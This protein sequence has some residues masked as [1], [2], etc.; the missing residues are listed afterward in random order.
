MQAQ[1]IRLLVVILLGLSLPAQA[2]I[3]LPLGDGSTINLYD[4]SYALLIGVSDYENWPDLP[5]VEED[6]AAVGRGL[7]KHGFKVISLLNPTRS[8]FDNTMR[9]FIGDYGQ[10]PENRLIIYYAGH[11]YTLTTNR[12]RELGYI[13]PADAPLPK[14]GT[15]AFKKKAISMLEIEIFAKQMESKHAMFTFDSC[16]SG[17]LFEITRA[18]PDTISLKTSEPVRQFITAGSAE[19]TVPD[20]S[21]FRN[22]FVA[23]LEGEADINKDGFITGTELAQYIEESVTNYTRRAQTPQYG[24][25]RDPYLDKG[26]FVFINPKME[27][28]INVPGK[29]TANTAPTSGQLDPAAIELSYWETIKGTN[30]PETYKAYLD[31]YPEGKFSKLAALLIKQASK[32]EERNRVLKLEREEEQRRQVELSR[33]RSEELKQQQALFEQQQ[34]ENEQRMSEFKQE[35]QRLAEQREVEEAR[36]KDLLNKQKEALEH[37]QALDKSQQQVA[38]VN[39]DALPATDSVINVKKLSVAT[40]VWGGTLIDNHH[41][42]RQMS[43]QAMGEGMVDTVSS[44]LNKV[45]KNKNNFT[46]V[47]DREKTN[48]IMFEGDDNDESRQIC[49]QHKVDKVIAVK[50]IRSS[51]NGSAEIHLYDCVAGDKSYELADLT[52]TRNERFYL[53]VSLRKALR[54]FY[55][56]N[57]EMLSPPN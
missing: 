4:K 11:G 7:K 17:S 15:G 13:V 6:I 24:K 21:V 41:F 37:Q 10:D 12:G 9:N 52:T 27:I 51:F 16:F 25:I 1:I 42:D 2:S 18:V 39:R 30:D 33:I 34:R 54:S 44:S 43:D 55:T 28:I 14:D 36:L 38:K 40:V 8:S 53:E 5:G 22:Q 23:G 45:L 31:E 26:D 56:E 57:L 19:Q 48:S 50:F 3:S 32:K 20:K 49:T 35:Q 46:R 29:E 47:I